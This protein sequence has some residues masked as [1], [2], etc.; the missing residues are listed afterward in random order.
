M[1][2]KNEAFFVKIM[3]ILLQKPCEASCSESLPLRASRLSLYNKHECFLWWWSAYR[4]DS[5]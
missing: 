5:F 1:T 2:L 3:L 4:F